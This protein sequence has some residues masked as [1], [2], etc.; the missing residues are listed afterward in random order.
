MTGN[1]LSEILSL[2]HSQSVFCSHIHLCYVLYLCYTHSVPD[3]TS[4]YIV[5]YILI[6]LLAYGIEFTEFDN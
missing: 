4:C 3:I 5:L 2:Q 1:K 6:L